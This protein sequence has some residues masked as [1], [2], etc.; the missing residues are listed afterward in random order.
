MGRSKT[1]SGNNLESQVYDRVYSLI[2]N[3]D[4]RDL[5]SLNDQAIAEQ[6]GVSRTPVRMALARLESEGLVVKVEGKGWV[7]A[8]L[9]L[10][11]INEIFDLKENLETFVSRK[12]AEKITPEKS[13]ELSAIVDE[14]EQTAIDN[15]IDGWFVADNKFHDLLF[16]LVGNHRLKVIVKR[17]NQQYF[18]FSYG[19][20]SMEGRISE[21]YKEHRR[22]AQ[23]IIS[24]N[25]DLAAEY[26]LKHLQ[27]IR[28]ILVNIIQNIIM[29]FIGRE[30]L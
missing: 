8:P 10:D 29:P 9:T 4:Y 5:S 11:D 20:M 22:I 16:D 23:A 14:M 2:S 27:D 17:I 28:A 30:I 6:M 25:P 15:D 1:S 3:R 24:K 12:A 13:M 26:T 19:F 7:V 21:M 18:R